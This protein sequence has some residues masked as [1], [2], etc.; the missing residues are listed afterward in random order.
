MFAHFYKKLLILTKGFSFY[1]K[2]IDEIYE[3]QAGHR[4]IIGFEKG[5]PVYSLFW[6][7]FFSS[8]Y[9]NAALE[10]LFSLFKNTKVPYSVSLAVSDICNSNCEHCSFRN[11]KQDNPMMSLEEISS[12]IRQC[13]EL[14]VFSI[15]LVGGEP[16]LNK[17]ITQIVKMIDQKRSA[18]LI[19]TN[20]SLLA[21]KASSLKK[22]GLRRIIV[23]IDFPEAQKHDAFRKHPGLF[24]K[25]V[26][27]IRQA[28][29]QGM[30]VGISITINPKTR[31]SDLSGLFE[32]GR[33]LKIHEIYISKECDTKNKKVYQDYLEDDFY[34]LVK[35][36]NQ[37]KK[38]KFGIFYYP[39]FTNISYGCA[40]GVT[41]FYISPYGDI[42]PCDFI[43]TSFGN[44]RKE[45]I[46]KIWE[47]MYTS[48]Q[49]GFATKGCRANRDWSFLQMSQKYQGIGNE[50]PP[51]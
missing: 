8:Q 21:E 34:P 44:M 45:K 49:M 50:N 39:F 29:R 6:P 38:Y 13:H 25:A 16:L 32:L 31:P 3:R 19:F 46:R 36:A 5:K 33:M 17:D 20:G 41:R 24:E 4:K 7:A 11:L 15:Y 2:L 30:L 14:G 12:C 51:D 18:L 43:P 37:N 1:D 9:Q 40:A 35:E 23:S 28:K 47:R 22:A 27:G 48:P 42:N 26:E 10:I